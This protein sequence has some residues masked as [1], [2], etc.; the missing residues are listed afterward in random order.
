MAYLRGMRYELEKQRLPNA[1]GK[2]QHTKEEDPQFEVLPR[3]TSER[4][5]DQ[6]RVS[7]GTSLLRQDLAT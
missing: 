2:N 1:E 5:A 7:R 3:R 4:L 6:Y